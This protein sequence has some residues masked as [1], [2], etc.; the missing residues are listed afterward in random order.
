LVDAVAV[1]G[2]VVLA[3]VLVDEAVVLGVAVLAAVVILV[4]VVPA[5]E[6]ASGVD[7]SSFNSRCHV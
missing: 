6:F 4:V 1:L 3:A 2:V 5:A 7:S